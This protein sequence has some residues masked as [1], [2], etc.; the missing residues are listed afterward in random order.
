MIIE[1][2]NILEKQVKVVFYISS[3]ILFKLRH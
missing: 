1:D 3:F 2:N